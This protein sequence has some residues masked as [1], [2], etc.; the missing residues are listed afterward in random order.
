MSH[1]PEAPPLEKL[2]S[3]AIELPEGQKQLKAL[4]QRLI[5]DVAR[6]NSRTDFVLRQNHSTA[7]QLH[8]RLDYLEGLLRSLFEASGLQ[9][10]PM[11]I[12]PIGARAEILLEGD[13]RIASVQT[14]VM[15][16]AKAHPVYGHY[17]FMTT[18]DPEH[19]IEERVFS[20]DKLPDKVMTDALIEAVEKAL[21][22]EQ[23]STDEFYP[24]M[25]SM[26]HD[27]PINEDSVAITPVTSEVASDAS[28]QADTQSQS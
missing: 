3:E 19:G 2:S 26:I 13:E 20:V 11:R 16:T 18:A 5:A 10:P 4:L 23:I 28:A 14:K 27:R 24:V 1:N 17:Q 22:A 6:A 21:A 9:M 15:K 25:I 12:R 7:G 8:E